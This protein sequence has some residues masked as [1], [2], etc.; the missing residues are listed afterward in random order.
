M[1][2]VLIDGDS[3]FYAICFGKFNQFTKTTKGGYD[4]REYYNHLDL[5]VEDIIKKTKASHYLAFWTNGKVFRHNIDPN[6]KSGR[7]EDKPLFFDDIRR[8]FVN[9]WNGI[10]V[11]GLEA[12][13]LV[14]IYSTYYLENN[15]EYCIARIDHD[16]DQLE[17]EHYNFKDNNFRTISK[18]ESVLNLYRQILTGC[19]TDKV[20]GLKSIGYKKA[21][22][23][24]SD[25]EFTSNNKYILDLHFKVLDTYIK[26]EG[27]EIGRERY[28]EVF[29]LIY[30]LRSVEQ[31]K[32][33]INIDYTLQEPYYHSTVM[34]NI[35][36]KKVDKID[37]NNNLPD[38]LL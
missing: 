7:P 21:N 23:L 14:A 19:V 11:K 27:W 32:Y 3:L 35:F 8:Y 28:K 10:H 34:P 25:I 26:Y 36:S 31:V 15:I 38:F 24:L 1:K 16:L 4:I 20:I 17:G 9:K 18:S 6:Y 22:K 30:L 12:E 37:E 33:Y 2:V 5:W 29:D 13:D